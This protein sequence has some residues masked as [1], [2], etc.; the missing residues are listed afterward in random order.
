MPDVTEPD[1]ADDDDARVPEEL[2]ELHEVLEWTAAVG[3]L[4]S[5]R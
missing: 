5:D 4:E 1:D 2:L 3:E